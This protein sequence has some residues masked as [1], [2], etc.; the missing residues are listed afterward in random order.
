MRLTSYLKA[1]SL[2]SLP[3]LHR[4]IVLNFSGK[5]DLKSRT[6]FVMTSD[7]EPAATVSDFIWVI[8]A[9]TT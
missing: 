5:M 8:P 2:A 7:S 9:F 1:K 4:Y 6:Y 3:E